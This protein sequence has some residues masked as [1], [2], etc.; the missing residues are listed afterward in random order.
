MEWI[1]LPVVFTALKE[2]KEE[3]KF[4]EIET[5]VKCKTSFLWPNENQWI[6]SPP[7]AHAGRGSVS[8]QEEE[9]KGLYSIFSVY[10]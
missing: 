9:I 1:H 7:A 6:L 3:Q 10:G 5:I 2:G 4:K 8:A